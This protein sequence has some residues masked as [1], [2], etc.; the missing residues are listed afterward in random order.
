MVGASYEGGSRFG[1]GSFREEIVAEAMLSIS[2]DGIRLL[3]IIEIEE[4]LLY[5]G[6]SEGG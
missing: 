1:I 2:L 5:L 4:C 3:E 6:E